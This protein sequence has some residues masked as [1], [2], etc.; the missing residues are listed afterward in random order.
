MV[1]LPAFKFERHASDT[2]EVRER[3][4]RLWRVL[5]DH[6]DAMSV[7]Q[8]MPA[9]GEAA[10]FEA[11]RLVADAYAKKAYNGRDACYEAALVVYPEVADE[12]GLYLAV[13]LTYVADTLA[14]A[15]RG[16]AQKCFTQC[17]AV[18]AV[19]TATG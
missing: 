6:A 1:K 17:N 11:T 12:Q 16:L 7:Q 15:W 19:A 8:R 18:A 13:T 10:V 14:G 4:R 3:E 2:V 5:I 9:A